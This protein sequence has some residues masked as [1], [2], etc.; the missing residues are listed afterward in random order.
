MVDFGQAWHGLRKP[1][2]PGVPTPTFLVDLPTG[3][4]HGPPESLTHDRY[5]L[6]PLRENTKSPRLAWI[7]QLPGELSENHNDIFNFRMR[8]LVMALV[9]ISGAVMSLAEDVQGN[10]E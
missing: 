6:D 2:P 1:Q 7:F 8:L 10:F 5:K 9:Q 4:R 3:E